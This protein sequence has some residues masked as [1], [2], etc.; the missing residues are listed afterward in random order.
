M[1]MS[2]QNEKNTTG[3]SVVLDRPATG[4]VYA[5]LFEKINLNP[6]SH[7]S[8]LDSWQDAQTMS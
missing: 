1:L 7:L 8:A 4:S 3:E 5:T 2:V 6:V